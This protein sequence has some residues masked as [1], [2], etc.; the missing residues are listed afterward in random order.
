[1]TM[2]LTKLEHS[3]LMLERGTD[4][5]LI[6]PGKFTTPLTDCANV[7]AVVITHEHDDHWTKE[8][9]GR[10]LAKSPGATI[11]AT[12][13]VLD[14]LA[15]QD[16][17]AELLR[18]ASPGDEAQA[19]PFRLRFHGGRHA[20]I[21]RSIP[22]VDNVGVLVDE[23]FYAGGDAYDAPRDVRIGTLAVPAYGPWMRIADSIDYILELATRAV[24]PVHEMTLARAGKELAIERLRWAAEE[25][26]GVLLD[27]APYET[28]DLRDVPDQ[29]E[30]K[31]EAE[32]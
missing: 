10:V 12:A 28:A 14:Q 11:F 19:G 16:V 23:T 25:A 13:A 26:G 2:R 21:H 27:L 15:S 17:E 24:V 9:I 4:R 30:A 7:A 8:Q 32:S 1:M 18:L 22:R 31:A 5:L 3:C 20:E 6:D 29:A